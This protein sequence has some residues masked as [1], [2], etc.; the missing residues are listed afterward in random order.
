MGITDPAVY[1]AASRQ[2]QRI[3]VIGDRDRTAMALALY[4]GALVLIERARLGRVID[5]AAAGRLVASLS[6]LE[7]SEGGEFLGGVAFWLDAEFLRPSVGQPGHRRS[8]RRGALESQ[9]LGAFAGR[10]PAGARG[11][12]PDG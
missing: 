11:G 1:A 3:A 6:R 2:A 9:V 4:Q 10:R 8:R 5:A 12:R 7:L